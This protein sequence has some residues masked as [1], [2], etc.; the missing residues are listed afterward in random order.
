VEVEVLALAHREQTEVTPCFQPLLLL[1]E[2]VEVLILMQMVKVEVQ[3]AVLHMEE[4]EELLPPDKVTLVEIILQLMEDPVVVVQAQQD[5]LQQITMAAM[6]A[7]EH[8]RR[9]VEVP[10]NEP[11][12]EAAVLILLPEVLVHPAAAQVEMEALTELLVFQTM[13]VAAEVPVI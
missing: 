6:A 3:A 10:C 4:L 12:V 11:E 13:A 1:A 2:V 7:S 8:H 5:P 9:L